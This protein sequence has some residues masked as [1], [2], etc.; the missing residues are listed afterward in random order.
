[1][2]GESLAGVP[3]DGRG[4]VIGICDWGFDFTHANFRNPDGTTRLQCLWDQRGFGDPLAPA[5]YNRGR[6]L[7]RSAINAALAD[8]DPCAALG[9]Y[10]SSGDPNNT[11][12]HGTHVHHRR[13]PARPALWLARVGRSLS[14]SFTRSVSA[15]S[16]TWAIQWAC[17]GARLLPSSGSRTAMRAPPSAGKTGG[18]KGQQPL[19]RA[20]DAML[21]QPDH[22][23]AE[24]RQLPNAAMHAHAGQA[25]SGTS[26]VDHAGERPHADRLGSGTR[27]DV[28]DVTL[29][30]PDGREF[31]VALGRSSWRRRVRV[32][33]LLPS[34]A[35][36]TRPQSHR[37]LY[38]RG[39]ERDG[40]WCCTAET[41]WTDG[42]THGS[43]T[44]APLAVAVLRRKRHRHDEHDLQLLPRDRRQRLR[45]HA[46]QSAADGVQRRVPPLMDA[47]SR[48]F[49][50]ARL[51][52]KTFALV[53]RDGWHDEPRLTVKS[54]SM[55]GA[56]GVGCGRAHDAPRD[57]R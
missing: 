23:G 2:E 39:P 10:P 45:R 47:R 12:S 15:S 18:D 3:E 40:E 19:Q 31:S 41:S 14:C 24:R 48:R 55:G 46:S 17:S 54:G 42:C 21:K 5:P 7:T 38:Y 26:S 6:L 33:Q 11:G 57:D 16:P 13:Q 37:H 53:P 32:G 25:T 36:P 9:Y 52:I 44:P 51:R 34:P 22:P 50:S 43:R 27:E 20:V 56:V 35:D 28:F 49:R 30:S 1:M 4:V 29:I 8:P